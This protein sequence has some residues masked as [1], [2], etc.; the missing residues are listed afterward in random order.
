MLRHCRFYQ[1]NKYVGFCQQEKQ[2]DKKG[3]FY[4]KDYSPLEVTEVIRYVQGNKGEWINREF[5]TA[6]ESIQCRDE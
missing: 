6:L 3:E 2:T 4:P 5:R 1:G